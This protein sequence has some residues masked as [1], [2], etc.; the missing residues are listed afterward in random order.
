M[1][2]G[3]ERRRERKKE[4]ILSASMELFSL[5]GTN[6]VSMDDIAEKAQVSKVT[7]YKY[8]QSKEDLLLDTVKSA[9]S[10]I[11]KEVKE[12][13]D[14]GIDFREKLKR[15]ILFKKEGARLFQGDFLKLL[16]SCDNRFREFYRDEFTAPINGWMLSLLEEGKALGYIEDN[17][18]P[19]TVLA[20]IKILQKGLDQSPSLFQSGEDLEG[21]IRLFFY[22]IFKSN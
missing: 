20:Y 13:L 1:A 4:R 19:E 15:V 12:I 8:F 7:I 3:H 18:S 6:R 2:T 16:L 10:R 5:H 14:S 17:L 21:M 22:G 9:A 11:L